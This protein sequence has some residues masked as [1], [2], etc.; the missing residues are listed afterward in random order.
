VIKHTRTKIRVAALVALFCALAISATAAPVH[1]VRTDLRPLIRAASSSR[2]QFAV[3]IPHAVSI[4]KDGT[5]SVEGDRAVWRYA[6]QVPTAVSLSFHATRSSLPA[7]AVLVV[8]GAKTTT[9]YR[10]SDLH[11]GELWSRIHPG[12]A[13]ELS[14]TVA[15][16]DRNQVQFN[17]TSLQA[18]YR[19]LGAGVE[20]HPYYRQVTRE[21]DG[22]ADSACVTNYEC[23]VTANNTPAGAAT[24][25]LIIGNIEQCTG[26]LLNDVPG[27]ETPYV[28]TARHCETGLP[29]GGNPGAASTVTV[30]WDAT[31]PCGSNLGSIYDGGLQTQTGAQTVVEQQDAWLIKLDVNPVVADA[32]FAGFDASGGPVNDGYTIHHAEGYDKQ[33]TSWFGQALSLQESDAQ[34]TRYVSDFLET[35]NQLGNIAPGASG[36]GLFDQ[37]NHLVGSLTLGRVTSDSSAYGSC[38]VANPTAPNGT[39]GVADFTALA[40]VWN[41]TADATSSTGS[42]T[43]QSVLDPGRSGTL[44]VPSQPSD[45]IV[46]QPST[47]DIF[48]VGTTMQLAWNA[49]N[50]TQCMTGGGNSGDGWSGT[51]ANIGAL[52]VSENSSATIVYTLTC[53]FPGG[54]SVVASLSLIWANQPQ[55]QFTAPY[56]VWT[57]T[58][59]VLTWNSNVSPCAISGGA[60][61]LTNLPASGT[62]TTTQATAGEVNYNITCGPADNSDEIS[63]AVNY[64]APNLIFEANGTDRLL[65]QTFFL[66]WITQANSCSPSGGSP[67]DGWADA[68]FPPNSSVAQFTPNVTTAGTYTYTL[69]CSTGSLSVQQST[70]VTF[71]NNAPYVTATLTPTT[72]AFSN[73]PADYA[74]LSWN[75]NYS[76]CSLTS[77]T[78]LANI[79]V[80]ASLPPFDSNT[81]FLT[82]PLPLGSMTAAPLHSGTYTG[83]ITCQAPG[84]NSA[85]VT[86]APVTLTVLPA[87]AP[88]AQVSFNPSTVLAGET[89]S[90]SW[91]S[92]STLNCTQSGGI[93]NGAWGAQPQ[94][95]AS[96]GS[97]SEPA[98]VGQFTYLLT[99]PSIDGSLP[100]ATAQATLNIVA[101]SASLTPGTTAIT[102][103]NPFT[104]TWSSTG[105]TGCTASGGG[106]NG[107]VWSGAVNPSGTVTQ[108]ATTAGTFMY[109]LVCSGAGQ[110]TTPQQ[111]TVTVSAASSGSSGGGAT[112]GGSTS[113]HGGGALGVFPLTFLA[114]LCAWRSRRYHYGA[115]AR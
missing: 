15:P 91:T 71:E 19:S 46:F 74:T 31:T 11:R 76:N 102:V 83:S 82:L 18:G 100:A 41:S 48:F 85:T 84:L 104:L 53:T 90:I 86:S 96:A 40:G 62:T 32:Q 61:A 56:V 23:Q 75:S 21:L 34:A 44:V 109:S 26:S 64:V 59:A 14:L 39:N 95:Q 110:S 54:R 72:V 8:R 12:D 51:V 94:P 4:T 112:T 25:A 108:T 2:V 98:V 29:G 24:V 13:L 35:V 67:N 28:L 89:F 6:V 87:A 38:P 88:T 20:D 93:P 52:T 113:S 36:S 78:S 73:S 103:G 30:Y 17:L 106:A 79:L 43:L 65:G 77:G 111:A 69:T 97:V 3:S 80:G 5:W 10:G 70:T 55:V 37:N 58:P 42:A 68:A 47:T 7:S 66:Q 101:L 1:I 9:S 114:G 27:D 107:S 22:S 57:T 105:A 63:E 81:P 33:F 99:C 49:A 50:A 45:E 92:T 115:G 16:A 60:L